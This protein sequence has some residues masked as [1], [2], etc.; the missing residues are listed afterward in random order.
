MHGLAGMFIKLME[1]LSDEDV[2]RVDAV[3][4]NL[5]P[6]LAHAGKFGY[7]VASMPAHLVDGIVEGFVEARRKKQGLYKQHHE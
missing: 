5:R 6:M 2:K 7:E 1:M 4:P 3:S